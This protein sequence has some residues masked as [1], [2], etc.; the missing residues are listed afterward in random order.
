MGFAL[1]SEITQ[2]S[3]DFGQM[4]EEGLF[5]YKSVLEFASLLAEVVRF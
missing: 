1:R 5:P 4:E 2:T 3:D